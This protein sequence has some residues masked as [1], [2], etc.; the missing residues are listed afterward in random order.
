MYLYCILFRALKQIL[1]MVEEYSPAAVYKMDQ[2]EL[3]G[4]K[5]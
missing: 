1:P 4:W 3:R 5:S 2:S